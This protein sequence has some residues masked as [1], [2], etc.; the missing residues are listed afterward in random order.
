MSYRICPSCGAHLD[1]GELCDCK[2]EC[3]SAAGTA[4]TQEP[5]PKAIKIN[6]STKGP[7]LS[8]ERRREH[9]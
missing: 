2:K 3:A 1:P 8:N 5:K 6:S 4:K 9:E 7:A